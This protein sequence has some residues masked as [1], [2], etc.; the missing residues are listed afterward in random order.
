MNQKILI[1]ALLGVVVII[2]LAWFVTRNPEMNEPRVENTQE[3]AREGVT[4]TERAL[5]RAE[6]STELAALRA[7]IEAGETY[8]SL[9]DDFA[10]VRTRLAA[11]YEST[12]ANV[13]AEWNEIEAEFQTFEDSARAGTSNFLD[14]LA[15]LIANLSADVRVET[16]AE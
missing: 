4:D 10:A 1:W 7:R 15:S 14:T 11:S 16:E 2:A 13:Q 8:E 9:E 5:A 6:A 3:T 12:E